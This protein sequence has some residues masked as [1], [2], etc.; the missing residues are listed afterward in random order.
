MTKPYWQRRRALTLSLAQQKLEALVVTHPPD[1]FYLTGFTDEA[2]ALVVLR[3]RAVLITDGRFITQGK[4]ETSGV[5]VLQHKGGLFQAVGEHL[6]SL[7]VRSVGFDPMQLTV[8]QHK[9]L[10]KA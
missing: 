7:G 5:Q 8:A 9:T 4:D 10:Q 1:W 6:Q 3:N 2:G